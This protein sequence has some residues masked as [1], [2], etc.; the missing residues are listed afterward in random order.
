MIDGATGVLFDEQSVE[1]LCAAMLRLEQGR[2]APADC[3]RNAERFASE[4]F[5]RR[6]E[7]IIQRQLRFHV[8]G[9][10]SAPLRAEPVAADR[11]AAR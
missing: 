9:S 10:A 7:E 3:R 8:H 4:H 2:F 5:R 6:M 1:S 11:I